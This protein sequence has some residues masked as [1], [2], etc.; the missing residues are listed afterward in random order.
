MIPHDGARGDVRKRACICPPDAVVANCPAHNE[1]PTAPEFAHELTD[2]VDEYEAS[3]MG[4][5]SVRGVGSCNV[6]RRLHSQWRNGPHWHV[7]WPSERH[8]GYWCYPTREAAVLRAIE[9]N[10]IYAATDYRE[11]IA[12]AILAEGARLAAQHHEA[13]EAHGRIK[14]MAAAFAAVAR[15]V[16]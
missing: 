11:R 14:T 1:W 7:V 13:S 9:V 2:G 16:V 8:G 6:S 3:A 4:V 5:M 15:G 12:Q 10:A